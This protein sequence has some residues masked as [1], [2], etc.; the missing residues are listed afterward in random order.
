M[1]LPN[2]FQLVNRTFAR[3]PG[4]ANLLNKPAPIKKE[5]IGNTGN[6]EEHLPELAEILENAGKK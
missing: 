6:D 3:V 2:S 1:L 4:T 5:A